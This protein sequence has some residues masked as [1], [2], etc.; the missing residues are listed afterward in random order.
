MLS[1]DVLWRLFATTGTVDFY[2]AYRES[3]DQGRGQERQGEDAEESEG[4][5]RRA[6]DEESWN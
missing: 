1:Q 4:T 6:G 5:G 2:L 3:V